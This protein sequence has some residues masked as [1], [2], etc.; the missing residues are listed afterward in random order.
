MLSDASHFVFS[1]PILPTQREAG[2]QSPLRPRSVMQ[3]LKSSAT[4]DCCWAR[5][6]SLSFS[7]SESNSVSMMGHA[8]K[9]QWPQFPFPP[10]WIPLA[11]TLNKRRYQ[12]LW[13]LIGNVAIF[14]TLVEHQ[15][16]L[17]GSVIVMHPSYVTLSNSN[18]KMQTLPFA[19]P[20][21]VLQNGEP[22]KMK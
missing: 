7:T 15:G 10:M 19:G 8:S 11:S 20:L 4:W 21:T 3:G 17:S 9:S 5:T 13:T 6:W 16:S 14:R 22:T 2:L 1:Q 18:G 12:Q